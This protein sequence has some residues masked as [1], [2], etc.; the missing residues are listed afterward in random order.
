MTKRVSGFLAGALLIA[1]S[2]GAADMKTYPVTGPVVSVTDDAIVT[3]RG[4]SA[5]SLSLAVR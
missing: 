4:C 1:A 5:A 2:A 3:Q